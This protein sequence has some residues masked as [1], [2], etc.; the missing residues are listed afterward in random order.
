M[1]SMNSPL[2]SVPK[3]TICEAP[4]T[5]NEFDSESGGYFSDHM[6]C[7]STNPRGEWAAV[8]YWFGHT[9]IERYMHKRAAE[10]AVIYARESNRHVPADWF[11]VVRVGTPS[12]ERSAPRVTARERAVPDL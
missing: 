4:L 3:C 6:R 12:D 1:T 5:A 11:T 8:K 7:Y 10:R 9:H 2:S